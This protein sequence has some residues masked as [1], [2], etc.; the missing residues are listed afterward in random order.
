M[1]STR[2]FVRLDAVRADGWF[3]RLGEG[4]PTFGQLR[5]IVG[6]RFV[7][8]AF[9]AGVRITALTVDRR[10]PDATL[11][12]FVLGEDPTEQRLALG[13]FRRRLAA[14]LLGDEPLPEAVPDDP[15]PDALQRAIG[16]RYVLLAPIFGIKL[17]EMRIGGGEDATIL[18]E[19]GAQTEEVFIEELRSLIRDRVRGELS[20]VRSQSPFAI[21]LARVPEAETATEKGDAERVI[22]LLGA[23]PGPLSLLLRTSEGQSL[24]VDSKATLG[25][26]LGL[27]GSAYVSRGRFEWA[28]EVLRLGIQWAQ[29]GP[30]AGDVFRR[31]AE[32]CVARDRH[33]EAIGLFRRALS[34]GAAARDVLPTL[35]RCYAER[36][37]WV[38]ALVCA[39]EALALGV[40]EPELEALRAEG[41]LKLGAPWSKFRALV[42]V[43]SAVAPTTPPPG[44]EPPATKAAS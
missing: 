30:A 40:A 29:D 3:E 19:I 24:G 42:P 23:W 27:L 31:L 35:A 1:S 36:G 32:A 20:R 39:D 14:A 28:E 33:G 18:L 22:E 41:H 11:V 12:D 26:A 2:R 37:R 17:K 25:R 13:E 10:A 7:A 44:P 8:F 9:I 34:L 43:S 16:I 21:D 4:N 15:D 5:D 6:E 38:A